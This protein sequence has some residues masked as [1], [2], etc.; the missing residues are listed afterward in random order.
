MNK[1]LGRYGKKLESWPRDKERKLK[2]KSK[3]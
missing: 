3:K 2:R 1:E